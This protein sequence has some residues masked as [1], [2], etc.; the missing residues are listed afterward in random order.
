LARRFLWAIE[1]S[2]LHHRIRGLNRA[3]R[4]RSRRD[5]AQSGKRAAATRDRHAREY[6]AYR[7]SRRQTDT[8]AAAN[9]GALP[10]I[11]AAASS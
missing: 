11:A 9:N 4:N 3:P 6:F 7:Q 2:P 8:S 10:R 1:Y 5:Y